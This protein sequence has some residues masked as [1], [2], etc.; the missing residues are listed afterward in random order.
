QT[1]YAYNALDNLLSVTQSGSRP[2]NFTSK[3]LSSLTQATSPESGTIKYTYDAN[4][5]LATKVAPSPNQT[6]SSVTVSTTYSRDAL[7]RLTQKSYADSNS[8]NPVTP[9]SNY[10]YDYVGTGGSNSI[11]RLSSFY[12]TGSPATAWDHCYLHTGAG[13]SQRR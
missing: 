8:S 13:D 4:G 9:T 7:N 2:T 12:T 10:S 3:S 5:N 1:S 6:N 11:G